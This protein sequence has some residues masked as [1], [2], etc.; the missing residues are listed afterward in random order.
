MMRLIYPIPASYEQK[1]YPEDAWP[2]I[3]YDDTMQVHFNGEKIDLLHDGPAHTT[4]DSAVIFRSTNA[5]HLGGVYNHSGYPFIDA[6]NGATLEGVIKFCKATLKQVDSSTIVIPGHGPLAT[7][8]ELEQYIEM[9]ATIRDRMIVMIEDGASLE[10]VYAAKVTREWD[11]NN[12][13]NNG[14]IN[15]AYMSLT[16]KVVDR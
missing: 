10:E 16:H 12:G 3:T 7:V 9:L 13:D 15:R 6:G 11:K 4:G 8:N 2:A 1:A 14:C 5:V